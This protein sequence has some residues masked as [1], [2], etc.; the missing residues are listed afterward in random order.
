MESAWNLDNMCTHESNLSFERLKLE[1]KR[2]HW[3]KTEKIEIWGDAYLSLSRAEISK[4][5][6]F[7]GKRLNLGETVPEILCLDIGPK[8]WI[9]FDSEIT[10]FENRMILL[11][12]DLKRPQ[13]G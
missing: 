5:I 13:N 7:Q 1:L 3:L 8:P 2:E 10:G 12:I 11:K 6:N 9:S 4:L